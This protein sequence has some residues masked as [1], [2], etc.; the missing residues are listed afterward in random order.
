MKFKIES[1]FVN[2]YLY[3]QSQKKKEIQNGI[4][5]CRRRNESML[6]RAWCC[7][8]AVPRNGQKNPD[9]V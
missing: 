2:N 1:K 8:T 7:Y 9:N 3:S 5:G 6:H 4:P